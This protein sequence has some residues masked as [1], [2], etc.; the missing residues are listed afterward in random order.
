MDYFKPLSSKR[1]VHRIAAFDI[2]GDGRPGGF[3]CGSVVTEFGNQFFTDRASMWQSLQE[4]GR[5][6]YWLFA[7][8][9]EYDLPV[10]AGD[11]LF[12]GQLLF[13]DQGLLWATFGQ[14]RRRFRLYDSTNLFPGQSVRELGQWGGLP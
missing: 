7:H 12:T 6:G 9:L 13:K 1:R 5:R 14:G 11:D 10:V 8:N 3:I 4:H 2:E